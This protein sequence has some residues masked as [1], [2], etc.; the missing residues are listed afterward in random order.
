MK[1]I[2]YILAVSFFLLLASGCSDYLDVKPENQLVIEDFWKKGS[3]VEAVVRSCYRS[4][5]EPD[6][7]WRVGVWGE[8]RSDNVITNTSSGSDEKQID[9]VNIVSTNV[10][11]NWKS[12]YTVINLCNTVLKYAP[13]VMNRDPNFRTPDLQAK[14]AEVYA[15]R[16]LC[17]FYLV[18]TFRNVPFSSEATVSDNQD[19][20]IKQSKPDS[21]LNVITNDL[22]KAES[23][24]LDVYPTT[25]ETKGRM[26]KDAIRA[27]LADVYLWKSATDTA[28]FEKA[29]DYSN[30]ITYCDKLINA[31]KDEFDYNGNVVKVP[32]YELIKENA[33]NSIFSDG[34][35]IS[36]GGYTF[37]SYGV[38]N[39]SESIFELQFSSDVRDIGIYSVNDVATSGTYYTHHGLF[40]SCYTATTDYADPAQ[41]IVFPK[42]DTRRTD[43]IKYPKS[44]SGFYQI[45]KY[46]GSYISSKT[47]PY[48]SNTVSNWIF[49]R[50]TDVMLMK[51][52]AL[53]QQ[54]GDT[55]LKQ[56]L[57][58]VNTTYTRSNVAP[59]D[60]LV[61]NNYSNVP[62]MEKLVLLERQRELMFEGKRW[63]DLVRNA[64]RKQSTNDLVGYVL[65]KYSS[66]LSTITTKLSVMNGLYLPIFENELIANPNLKQNPYYEVSSTI[67]K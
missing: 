13:D 30:C 60:T 21:I 8:L 32:K 10:N 31:T 18:R 46:M 34:V 43:F 33:S 57:H 6:F 42:T 63:F 67:V 20:L 11:C 53:V 56:A 51:A 66:N 36:S 7:M 52:E 12:F 9:N 64:E 40:G 14:E 24:A 54:G 58:L 50:I 25:P 22:L 23:W 5:E 47:D 59:A 3:D 61:F 55:D 38:G 41:E 15:I 39:S 16:A 29:N 4:M 49:Y 19:L 62:A 2:K 35:S 17:Y 26:T 27:I 1:I 65:N 37:S 45:W 28:A 48:V 44:S